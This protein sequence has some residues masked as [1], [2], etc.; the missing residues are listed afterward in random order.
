MKLAILHA[1]LFLLSFILVD[2]V[3]GSYKRQYCGNRIHVTSGSYPRLVCGDNFL[4]FS[5]IR[6]SEVLQPYFAHGDQVYCYR[7]IKV[8]NDPLRY[9][10]FQKNPRLRKAILYFAINNCQEEMDKDFDED[11]YNNLL[12][13]HESSEER[14][15]KMSRKDKWRKIQEKYKKKYKKRKYTYKTKIKDEF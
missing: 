7:V 6:Q 14:S 11:D 15:N 8:L 5:Y 13:E 4:K 9:G 1:A 10:S 2:T 3:K 12:N